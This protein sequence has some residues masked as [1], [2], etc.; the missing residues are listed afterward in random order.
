MKISVIILAAGQGKRMNSSLP[1]VL[2]TVAGKSMLE[3]VVEKAKLLTVENPIVVFGYQGEVVQQALKHHTISWVLQTER[4]GTGHAALQGLSVIP[5]DHHV[6]ILYGDVPLISVAMLKQF[7]TTTPPD[8]LGIITAH[9][10][11]PTGIGRIIRDAK[12]NIL[13]VV[14]EK[15]ANDTQRLIQEVNTGFYF[16]PARY[17]KRWLPALQ[18]HNAQQEY[19]LTDIVGLAA[20]DN[21]PV[22]GMMLP[23]Y[24]EALGVNNASQL[25]EAE[26]WQQG[27]R[28]G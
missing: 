25:A 2:H 13:C 15:D 14:E 16:A 23:D 11:D 3:H 9:F 26:K 5:D 12:Q 19:Y 18:N 24:Q 8:A 28:N 1:K 22:F 7:V 27:F 4:L 21:I 17:L 20:R 6:L 10:P